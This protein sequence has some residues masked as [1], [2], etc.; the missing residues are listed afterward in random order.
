MV[1]QVSKLKNINYFKGLGTYY[2]KVQRIRK[3]SGLISDELLISKEKIEIASSICKVDLLSDLVGEFP[4]LQGVLW[5]DI[6]LNLKVLKKKL[7]LAVSEHYLPTGIDSK[8]T[9]ET[10]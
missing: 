7:C 2:D 6:L 8:I 10:F 1:K 3:L 4:E 5:E 9:K